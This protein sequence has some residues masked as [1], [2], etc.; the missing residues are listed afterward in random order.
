MQR[1]GTGGSPALCGSKAAPGHACRRSRWT[2][3]ARPGRDRHGGAMTASLRIIVALVVVVFAL[4]A[5]AAE[6][7]AVTSS[8]A[9]AT[10][11]SDTDRFARGGPF[12]VGLRLRMQPRWH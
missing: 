2:A 8:R 12:K 6:S 1:S 7:V 11:I 10:L 9:T 4:P 5:R 3:P